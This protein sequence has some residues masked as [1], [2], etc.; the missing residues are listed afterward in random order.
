MYYSIRHLTR[1]RYHEAITQS[2]MELRMQPRSDGLQRC[3]NFR[4]ALSPKARVRSYVD[5]LGNTVHNFDIPG[6]HRQ[7]TIAAEAFV[8]MRSSSELPPN[9]SPDAWDSV[10]QFAASDY[11][12]VLPSP[13]TQPTLLLDKLAAELHVARRDDPLS[14]LRELNTAIYNAFDYAPDSTKVDSPIDDALESRQG[15]CQDFSHIMIAL[16]RGLGIPCRYISGYLFHWKDGDSKYRSAE[17]A[18]HAWVE[19][20]LPGLGWVGFDPT[21]NLLCGERHIRVAIGRDY[22]DVPPTR[23]V[24]KGSPESELSVG[25]QVAQVDEPPPEIALQSMTEWLDPSTSTSTTEAERLAAEQQA[26][27]QQ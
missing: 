21:N 7:L 24:F 4:V 1:F 16:V 26:Q 12:F 23:G 11:D 6:Q 14:L 20:L 10:D 15:V 9:L 5:Y 19:A 13:F 8:E 3:L 27:Q 22:A 18:T 2:M 17:D 25:V